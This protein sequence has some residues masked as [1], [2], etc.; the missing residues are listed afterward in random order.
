MSDNL[1]KILHKQELIVQKLL[2]E[3]INSSALVLELLRKE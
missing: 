3:I 1:E 2:S